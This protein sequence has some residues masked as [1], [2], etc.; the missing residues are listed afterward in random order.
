[1]RLILKWIVRIG[2]ALITAIILVGL[3]KREEITRLLAVNSLFN[4]NR[5]VSNF[6][7]MEAAFLH[8]DIPRGNGPVSPLPEGTP[9]TMPDDYASWVSAR[10][11]T[12][13]L[14]LKDGQIVHEA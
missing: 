13:V 10:A 6:S 7:N 5:I 14:V 9:M 1:M 11:V 12:S 2:L 3:W 8:K 4:E